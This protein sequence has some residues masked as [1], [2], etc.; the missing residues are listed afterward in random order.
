MAVLVSHGC[1]PNISLTTEIPRRQSQECEHRPEGNDVVM[2]EQFVGA[3]MC[4][5]CRSTEFVEISDYLYPCPDKSQ[6]ESEQRFVHCVCYSV[7]PEGMRKSFL[8]LS[9][10]HRE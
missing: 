6:T 8:S 10:T 4:V 5:E 2:L 3:G 9:W 1:N 7:L